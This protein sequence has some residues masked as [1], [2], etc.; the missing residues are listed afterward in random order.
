T[1]DRR[2]ALLDLGMV[3]RLSPEIQEQLVKLLFAVSEGRGDEVADR[4]LRIG[5][6]RRR[7]DDL[8]YRRRVADLVGHFHHATASQLQVGR[9]LLEVSRAGAEPGLVLS[10]ELTLVGKTLLHLEAVSR[11]LAPD[12]DPSAA[13]R[14]HAG[15]VLGL[16]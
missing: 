5:R 10:S 4:G 9:V 12:S 14:R 3:A 2:L 7:F 6:R 8:E 13:A 16:R 11:T 15:A 1:D